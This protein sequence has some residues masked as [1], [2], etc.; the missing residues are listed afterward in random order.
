MLA[1]NR[2]L[3]DLTGYTP[4]MVLGRSVLELNWWPDPQA[5]NRFLE[6]LEREGAIR[7][8]PTRIP[9][10]YGKLRDVL[11]AADLVNLG[12]ERCIVTIALDVTEILDTQ[13]R[14]AAQE[15]QQR[16]VFHESF[17][18][19]FI[20]DDQGNLVDVNPAGLALL[21]YSRDE[22]I[23]RDFA[24]FVPPE[25]LEREPLVLKRL[26]PGTEAKIFQRRLRRKDGSE[27]TVEI[28]AWRLSDGRIAGIFRDL[29]QR[30][31]LEAQ[32]REAQKLEAIGRLAGGIAHDFNNLLTVII[33]S[34]QLLMDSLEEGPQKQDAREI[35]NAANRAAT[36]TRQLLAFSRRQAVHPETLDPNEVLRNTEK[37]LR[38][39]IGEEIEL[40]LELK[41]SWLIYIDPGQLDQVIMN[42]V[43]NAR[44]AM[45]RGGRLTLSTS[46]VSVS[47][48][49]L[50]HGSGI[51]EGDYVLIAL[52][53]TGVGMSPDI[54]EHIFEPFFTTKPVG[55]GTGLGLATVYGIVAQNGGHIRV[56]SQP[57]KGSTFY[58]YLPRTQP[59]AEQ[60]ETAPQEKGEREQLA[61]RGA[62]ILVVED[63][64]GVR[65]IV[66]TVLQ[67]GGYRILAF[68]SPREALETLKRE[69]P[70]VDLLV[71]DVVMP[72]IRG[73][74]L[75]REIARLYPDLPVL[76]LSGYPGDPTSGEALLPPDAPFIGKPFHP[77]ALAKTVR[78]ILE[79][80]P[81]RKN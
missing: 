22:I 50:A 47:A 32:M 29:T 2:A 38:R 30:A 12:G 81:K 5:R 42:L 78:S 53:D 57:G 1:C 70:E 43:V 61:A 3:Q 49:H 25:D 55:Q 39:V 71:S 48:V 8:Y 19:I 15:E 62:T 52:K 66:K 17:D 16:L 68:G 31:A 41:S 69:H 79:R 40:S 80:R 60:P 72:G 36:L 67:R 6:T 14:L 18:P 35:L 33:S 4:T 56:E 20:A 64:P 44:D 77:D 9:D 24:A 74:E 76:Y 58:L 46:D 34:T 13:R 10:A 75:H 7:N 63:D 54:L 73:P 11:L 37:L 45:P 65:G 51:P 21:G 23:G 27:V 59:Q 28:N 26:S